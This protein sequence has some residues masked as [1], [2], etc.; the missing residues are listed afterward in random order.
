LW[1]VFD[2]SSLFI[3]YFDYSSFLLDMAPTNLYY[4]KRPD[5][6]ELN[7]AMFSHWKDLSKFTDEQ[8]LTFE[9][10][11]YYSSSPFPGLRILSYNSEYGS[12]S[13]VV[14][15]LLRLFWDCETFCIHIIIG[16]T[17]NYLASIDILNSHRFAIKRRTKL[18]FSKCDTG[19]RRLHIK[20]TQYY[21]YYYYYY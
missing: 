11:L 6:Q 9:K 19:R 3:E 21:Y 16:Y 12:E 7:E 4:A 2:N 14:N 5:I 13:V 8:K 18:K 17:I 20:C 1:I 15:I 10:G